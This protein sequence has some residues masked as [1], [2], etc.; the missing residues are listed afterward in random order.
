M[1]ENAGQ[2]KADRANEWQASDRSATDLLKLLATAAGISPQDLQT[3]L[4]AVAEARTEL[5]ASANTEKSVYQDRELVYDDETAFIFRRGTTKS[6]TYYIR[7]YDDQ[8][9]RPFVKSLRETDRVAA[10]AKA[11]VIYQEIKGKV[12]RGERLKAIPNKE[13]VRLYLEKIERKVTTVPQQGITPET[14]RLKKYFL[15]IWLRFIESLGLDKTPIDQIQPSR[16]RDF[17]HWFANLPK[18]S[19]RTGGRSTEQVNNC[20][21]E[22]QRMFR[23]VGVRDRYISKE[24][25][26][27]ID[28]VKEQPDERYKRDILTTEQYERLN[29]FMW[30]NWARKKDV[31]PLER[32]K[33]LAFFY[34]MGLLYNT[35]LRPK[36][37]LGLRVHEI[38]AIESDDAEIRKTHLK[39][40]IRA[41]NSK[42]G[43]SRVV[44][45]PIKN[46]ITR[47]KEVYKEMGVEHTAQDYLLFN[48]GS[49]KRT[50]YTRQALYQR[51]Q[52]VLEKSGLKEELVTEGKSVSLYSARHAFITWRLQYGNVPIHLVAKVAG[53]SIQKIEQTYGHIEVEKQTELLTR[54]QG[55]ARRG[56][57]DL[58]ERID[59]E[60]P[61]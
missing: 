50:A 1:A 11:R 49:A 24:N 5:Q 61:R 4:S 37:L 46:R 35:G 43:R 25:I 53:T 48:P 36:E 22:V 34:T 21:A 33:R 26:P 32:Q 18:E 45:A 58:Q 59:A 17:G 3:A 19:G 57:V 30:N 55:Y 38:S 16:T 52:E 13:L 31:K 44:V 56:G 28:R 20:I 6:R 40:F 51:L 41:A 12:A 2:D 23:E 60:E 47:I 14:L 27:E 29:R 39:V 42:T 54:N 7:I 15:N 9:R 10:L 8:S